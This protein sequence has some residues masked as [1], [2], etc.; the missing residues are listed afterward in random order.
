MNGS[1]QKSISGVSN[2]SEYIT[3]DE[4]NQIKTG[5]SYDEVC[6]IIGSAGT[7]S[8]SVSSNGIS[9]SIYTWYGG[10]MAGANANVTF[11]NDSVTGKAQVGL[12]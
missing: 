5:M 3:K 7:L 11:T 9:I 12:K 6:E 4:F 2:N 8:S 1:I 10:G